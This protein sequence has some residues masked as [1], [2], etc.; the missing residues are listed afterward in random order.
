MFRRGLRD[1]IRAALVAVRTTNYVE[2][3]EHARTV[4]L[5]L[6]LLAVSK[7]EEKKRFDP[8]RS[9]FR[10]IGKSGSSSF[11]RE[12]TFP[13]SRSNRFRPYEPSISRPSW[14]SDGTSRCWKCER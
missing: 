12:E 5:E 7:E 4:E 6:S 13:Y 14:R 9:K 10:F 2:L 3:L 8:L 11:S 1:E